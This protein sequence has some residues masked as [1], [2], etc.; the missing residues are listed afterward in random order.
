M[1]IT[2]NNTVF[3]LF[4]DYIKVFLPDETIR[5]LD[6]NFVAPQGPYT[7]IKMV[8][9]EPLS[10]HPG[11]VFPATDETGR[12]RTATS[13]EGAIIIRCFGLD[14]F[15]RAVYIAH[16][17]RDPSLRH[18]YLFLNGLGYKGH[19]SVTDDS[20]PIDNQTIEERGTL[21][22]QFNFTLENTEVNP[23]DTSV[24][25]EVTFDPTFTTDC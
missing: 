23:N 5:I 11:Y 10:S 12:R 16:Q 22:V 19:S 24:I 7:A 4:Y 18:E 3:D 8:G 2:I 21:T 15:A 1:S 17:L 14:A 20:I 13:Y 25:E 6:S 9:M